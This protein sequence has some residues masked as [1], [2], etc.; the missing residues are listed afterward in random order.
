MKTEKEKAADFCRNQQ[1]ELEREIKL[2]E[3][4]LYYNKP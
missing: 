4:R 1:P 2:H 3:I